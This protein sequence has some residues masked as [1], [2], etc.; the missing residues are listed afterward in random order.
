MHSRLATLA[1]ADVIVRIYNQGI[2]DRIATFETEPRTVEQ[3]R[4][5]LQEK[6]DHH[7]TV[8]IEHDDKVIAFAWAS[9]YSSR[10]CYAGVAEHSVY[11][12]REARGLGAGLLALNAL[13]NEFSERGFWKLTSRIF[14]ENQAS[15][16]LHTRA[17]FR[18][19]GIHRR[20]GKLEGEWRDTVIVERLL[21]E[22]AD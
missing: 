4:A 1:D 6:G 3:V 15:L 18:E 8:V 16:K 20:H 13:A 12:A 5:T 14:P 17:G 9:S 22:A 10:P 2:E 11:V 21:G 19:V 7:P